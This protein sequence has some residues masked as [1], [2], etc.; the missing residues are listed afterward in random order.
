MRLKSFNL[1]KAAAIRERSLYR[2][3]LKLNRCF[4]LE[5]FG[6]TGLV[7]CSSR[8]ARSSL[9]SYALS[10]SRHSAGSTRQI[11]RSASGPSC[12][13]PPV[14][15]MAIRHG[16]SC[17]ALR[18]NG[19]QP[20]FSPPFSAGRGAVGF[21][22]GGFDHLRVCGSS[23]PGE[24]PE[25]IFPDAAPRPANKPVVDRR[26]RIVF[27]GQSHQRQPL[28]NTCTIPL[29]TRRSSARSTPRTSVGR[30]GSIRFH[31]SSLSQNRFLRMI[32]I[33]QTN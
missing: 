12:A 6:M 8:S 2:R 24:L 10:P 23:L 15:R 1:L 7:P 28:L 5:R 17:C 26:R 14:N 11:R 21:H 29:M 33:P 16:S 30:C 9:L 18:A 19:Q 13:S 31:C 3:L 4:L 27:G 22:V 20:A 32:P 25:Q